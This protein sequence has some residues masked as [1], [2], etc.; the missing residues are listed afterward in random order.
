V[1]L[2]GEPVT[3]TDSVKQQFNSSEVFG[4]GTIPTYTYHPECER[5]FG[6]VASVWSTQIGWDVVTYMIKEF[7]PDLRKKHHA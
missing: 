2:F 7:W 3:R 6:N 1:A 4:A 5:G